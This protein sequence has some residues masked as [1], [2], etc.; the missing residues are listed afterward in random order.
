MLRHK[1]VAVVGEE[2]AGCGL[3]YHL[4]WHIEGTM[5]LTKLLES[6]PFFWDFSP[7]ERQLFAN[8]DSFFTT[9]TNGETIITEGQT[10]D[11][12]LILVSGEVNVTT[13]AF[14]DKILTTL[15]TGAIIG[16]LSFLT[17]R[18]RTANII[19]KGDVTS[20]QIDGK[21]SE[22]LPAELQ[23]KV[24]VQLIEILVKRLEKASQDLARQKEINQTLVGALR[25]KI[26]GP[27]G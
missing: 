26:V 9:Y 6:I 15:E 18:P 3:A 16:E 19:A 11:G 7:E 23:K 27:E 1:Y 25:T 5:V 17:K 12:L 20:F 22:T 21:S 24:Q 8:N 14:P 2:G 13:N 10:D 4:V